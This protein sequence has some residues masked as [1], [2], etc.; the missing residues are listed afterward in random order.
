MQIIVDRLSSLAGSRTNRKT[1]GVP[2]GLDYKEQI[3]LIK[4]EQTSTHFG[5]FSHSYF[6]PSP[7]FRL[8]RAHCQICGGERPLAC[9]DYA[10]PF[11]AYIEGPSWFI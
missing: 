8:A 4:S 1:C 6:S 2:W 3:F 10:V 11:N 9:F 5:Y 7:I